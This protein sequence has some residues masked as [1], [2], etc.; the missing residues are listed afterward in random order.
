VTGGAAYTIGAIVF[1]REWPDPWPKVFGHHEI[2]HV[3]V[4][5]GALGHFLF[6]ATLL[7]VPV[8]AF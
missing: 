2:W 8:P 7:D 1:A 5:L 4:L 6:A 3:L